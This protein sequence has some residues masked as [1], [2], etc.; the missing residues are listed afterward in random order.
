VD[1]RGVATLEVHLLDFDRDIYGRHVR[2]EFVHKLRDEQKYPDLDALRRQIALDVE[3]TRR[4]FAA[5]MPEIR[6]QVAS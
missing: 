1:T 6:D 5:S 4:Y 2:V 3:S